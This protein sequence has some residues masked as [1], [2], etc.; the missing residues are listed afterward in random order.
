MTLLVLVG[1][2]GV[3]KGSIVAEILGKNTDFMLS[4]SATTRPPRPGEKD[5]LHYHFISKS[6]FVKLIEEGKL[7]EWAQVHGDHYYGTPLSEIE[8]AE[9]LGKH[10]VLEIDL[11]GARQLRGKVGNRVSVFVLPPSIAELEGRLRGRGTETEDQIQTRLDTARTEIA[12][13]SEFD[14]QTVNEDLA[15]TASFVVDLVRKH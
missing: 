6:E 4:V 13:A 15:Q 7:I 10:L 1:P 5:G 11:Q 14:F 3:G 8:R 9:R 2:A 12:A